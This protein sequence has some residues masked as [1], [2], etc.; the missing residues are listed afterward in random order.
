MTDQLTDTP[1]TDVIATKPML[2]LVNP[3]S[4]TTVDS[5]KPDSKPLA[6]TTSIIPAVEASEP[7]LQTQDQ[8][9]VGL[10][11]SSAR[12]VP[13]RPVVATSNQADKNVDMS[14]AGTDKIDNPFAATFKPANTLGASSTKSST[15][16][17]SGLGGSKFADPAY[18]PPLNVSSALRP[19]PLNK[20]SPKKPAA[21]AMSPKPKESI[22]GD[23]RNISRDPD[24]SSTMRTYPAVQEKSTAIKRINAGAGFAQMLKDHEAALALRNASNSGRG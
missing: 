15:T 13:D 11:Y 4:N 16:S 8:P 9:L 3:F 23:A 22:F 19:K 14:N 12:S 1:I 21:S 20:S 18:K 6:A 5:D 24:A 2:P 10:M 7:K 17:K